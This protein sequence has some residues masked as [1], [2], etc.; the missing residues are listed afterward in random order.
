V[1]MR[2]ARIV[3]FG[4]PLEVTDIP[5]PEIGPDDVLVK[6]EA[7]GICRTDWHTWRGEWGWIGLEPELPIV[8]GHEFAGVVVESGRD[9][10]RFAPGDR[11]TVPF[12]DGCGLCAW[13]TAGR[14]NLC[15]RMKVI[16]IA[17]DGGYA[18]YVR[19]PNADFNAIAVPEGIDFDTA[20]ALGCRYMTAFHAVV[21]RGGVRPG[22]WVAIHGVG[23]VGLSA[24]QIASAI[25]ARPVAVDLDPIKL[26]LA[27][28]QGAEVL[29]DASEG[30]PARMVR[31]LT[32]GGAQVSLDALGVTQTCRNSI[33]SLRRGGRHVQVGLTTEE[34]K[35]KIPVPIDIIVSFE[36][37]VVG[38]VGNP[39]SQFPRLLT[40]VESGTLNPDQ[41]ITRRVRLD[42]AGEV[43][44]EMSEYGTRGFN[45][46]TR[47]RSA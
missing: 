1:S 18:E 37:E 8:P 13:C 27:R 35:G 44:Q 46:I 14:S 25:G 32:G 16:G 15:E 9:V 12:H 36:L 6:V 26:E 17:Y 4:A 20:A 2:A 28:Q 38:S 3:E 42:Q 47:F 10:T 7:E 19:I 31:D 43:L 30:D 29:V 21:N 39:R 23:G 45:L 24:V 34:E 33:L 41:L 11:V 40:M 5:E 22:D